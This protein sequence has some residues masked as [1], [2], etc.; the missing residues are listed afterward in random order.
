MSEKITSHRELKVYRLSF[1]LGMELFAI[2]KAFPKEEIYSM[3]DHIK[4][5]GDRK[6]FI[7]FAPRSGILIQLKAVP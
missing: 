1:D 2:T 7:I 6:I 4:I 3:T 5:R